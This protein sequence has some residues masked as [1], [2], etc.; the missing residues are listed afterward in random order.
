MIAYQKLPSRTPKPT[1]LKKQLEREEKGLSD[2][3]DEESDGEIDW[4]Q[5]LK[6][7]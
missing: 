6:T 5:L 3:D 1:N 7:G 2:G 4:D